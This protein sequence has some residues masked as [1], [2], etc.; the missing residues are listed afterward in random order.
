MTNRAAYREH[1][2]SSRDAVVRE[3]GDRGRGEEDFEMNRPYDRR[4]PEDILRRWLGPKW[5]RA[6]QM[7]VWRLNG[8]TYREIAQRTG[9][10]TERAR[11]VV[12]RAERALR[13]SAD[14]TWDG[15]SSEEERS[16]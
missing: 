1:R 12:L 9:V 6:V 3:G 14:L 7:M 5:K 16:R 4:I 2:P 8:V 11:Q 13:H 10:T 15:Y